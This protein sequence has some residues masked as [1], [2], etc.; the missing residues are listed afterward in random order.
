M[1][2]ILFKI[3]LFGGVT[4]Y[5]YG[6]MVAAGFVAGIFWIIYETRKKGLD[7]GKAL[8]LIFYI[9]ISSIIGSRILYLI[10][11]DPTRLITEPWSIFMVWEGGLVFFGGLI[12]AGITALIFFWKYKMPIRIYLDVF[13]PA[14][15]IGHAFGRIG[16]FM[17]GCCHGRPAS[18]GWLR[19]AL[20]FPDN[21]DTFAPANIPLY[22][23]Q[24]IEAAGELTIFLVLILFRK[25]K[26]FRGQV[27]ALYLILYSV[28]RF[29]N[30]FL[31]GDPDR[32]YIIEDTLSTSQGVSIGL[33]ILGVVI[34]IWGYK[35]F[36]PKGEKL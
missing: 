34:M 11:M 25:Y 5:T 9:I 14:L 35:K 2:P 30:E 17:V 6:F 23:T 8:D 16:C 1:H 33:F 29:S 12:A 22:P 27:F 20:T 32:G 7:T 26:H 3:P 19:F 4:V 28:L 36:G 15:A 24:L 21:P 13:A 31:R 18:S 10:V